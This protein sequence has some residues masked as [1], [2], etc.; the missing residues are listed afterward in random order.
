MKILSPLTGHRKTLSAFMPQAHQHKKKNK[1][2]LI[3]SNI[4]TS[5]MF[6]I[7]YRDFL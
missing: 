6:W 4:L 2:Y 7:Q 5:D 1:L 3:V